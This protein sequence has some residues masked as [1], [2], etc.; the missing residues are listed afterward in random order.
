MALSIL[1]M[2]A[3][4]SPD[5]KSELG[6]DFPFDLETG[7]IRQRV[8]ERWLSFDPV[9]LIESYHESLAKLK[10]IYLDCG[11]RDEF[12]MIW[13]C[14]MIHSK[15]KSMG[16]EHYYEEFDGGHRKIGHRY[17]VSLPLIYQKMMGWVFRAGNID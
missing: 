9:R 3:H 4:Y 5:S 14:R 2:A 16:I 8:W 13:G 10:L 17:D 1:G 11:T 12:N 7:E 15:L 6:V